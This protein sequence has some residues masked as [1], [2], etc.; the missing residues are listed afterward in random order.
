VSA[1]LAAD[2]SGYLSAQGVAEADCAA[3]SFREVAQGAKSVQFRLARAAARGRPVA[4]GEEL[5]AM[6]RGWE[7]AVDTLAERL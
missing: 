6:A 7:S 1:E 2:L 4:V 3:A 5:A